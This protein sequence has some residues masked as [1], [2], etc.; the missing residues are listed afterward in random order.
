M[1]VQRIRTATMATACLMCLPLA[2]CSGKNHPN[3]ST[4]HPSTTQASLAADAVAI[5][6]V[7]K[8]H[9][10]H[11]MLTAIAI[12]PASAVGG[13]AFCARGTAVD[14]PG[15]PNIGHTGRTITCSDGTILMGMDLHQPDGKSGT[16]RL[17]S[18]TGAY[19]GWTGSG[20]LQVGI[21]DDATQVA[22]EVFNGTV[23]R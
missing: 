22:Q 1:R 6:I 11:G 8:A 19:R 20:T 2:G 7:T 15:N 14:G 10:E 13:A 18:G 9:V 16:W 23:K 12:Q 5:N 17:V 3:Q 4:S 21:L